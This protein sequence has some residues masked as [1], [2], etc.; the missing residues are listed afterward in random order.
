M[1]HLAA[2]LEFWQIGRRLVPKDTVFNVV[3]FGGFAVVDQALVVVGALVH[4]FAERRVTLEKAKELLPEFFATRNYIVPQG[5]YVVDLT[6]HVGTH[7][8]RVLLTS[9]KEDA[10]MSY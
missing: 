7:V 6:S 4:D 9:H 1:K 8:H 2:H 5:K 3:G 10:A